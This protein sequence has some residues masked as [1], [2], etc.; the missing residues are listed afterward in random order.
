VAV[1]SENDMVSPHFR[2]PALL[3][4]AVTF[5]IGER[6]PC[7]LRTARSDY[8]YGGIPRKTNIIHGTDT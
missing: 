8:S 7:V 1:Y 2:I 3:V 6:A 5:A 4:P